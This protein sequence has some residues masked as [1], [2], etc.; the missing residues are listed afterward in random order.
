MAKALFGAVGIGADVRMQ[1]EVRRLRD[2]VRELENEVACLR[3]SHA[4]LEATV[5]VERD[6]MVLTAREPALT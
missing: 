5:A 4:E 2:R 3:S 6:L 1:A